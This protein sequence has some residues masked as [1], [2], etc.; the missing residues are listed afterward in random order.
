MQAMM[1]SASFERTEGDNEIHYSVC[2]SYAKC[3]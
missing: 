1:E 2:N 3:K